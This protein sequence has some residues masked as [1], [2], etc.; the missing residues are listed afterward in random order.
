MKK[1]QW[2]IVALVSLGALLILGGCATQ[3]PV[4]SFTADRVSGDAPLTVSFT[5]GT[6]G[7]DFA[8]W[9]FGDGGT[10]ADWSPTHIFQNAGTYTV[11]LTAT[12]NG[13]CGPISISQTMTIVVGIAPYVNISSIV[14]SDSPACTNLPVRLSA[15]IEHNRPIVSYKWESSDGHPIGNDPSTTFTFGRAGNKTIYLTVTDDAG[16][17]AHLT[18]RLTVNDCHDPCVPDDVCLTLNPRIDSVR[19]GK[20]FTISADFEDCPCHP[21]NIDSSGIVPMG[22]VPSF[23]CG[24]EI[25]WSV[26]KYERVGCCDEAYITADTSYYDISCQG[27]NNQCLQITFCRSGNYRVIAKLYYYGKYTSTADGYYAVSN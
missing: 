1:V 16:T 15:I 11:T 6:F 12:S 23:P 10:S 3:P 21:C 13:Y 14:I 25:R 22:I 24:W 17:V 9:S 4:V 18:T 26:E 7:A 5:N 20:L 27:D 8:D 19:T 2:I